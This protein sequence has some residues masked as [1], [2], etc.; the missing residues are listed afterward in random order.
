MLAS[1]LSLA[2]CNSTASS[3]TSAAISS[4]SLPSLLLHQS[5]V[6][7]KLIKFTPVLARQVYAG[8]ALNYEDLQGVYEAKTGNDPV[9]K[10]YKPLYN[11]LVAESLPSKGSGFPE[12]LLMDTSVNSSPTSS[13][14]QGGHAQILLEER[15]SAH[16]AWRIIEDPQTFMSLLPHLQPILSTKVNLKS[17]VMTPADAVAITTQSFTAWENGINHT[18]APQGFPQILDY[19]TTFVTNYDFSS[20]KEWT[21]SGAFGKGWT[22]HYNWS[23]SQ[24]SVGTPI[25]IPVSGGA[26]VFYNAELSD[27]LSSPTGSNRYLTASPYGKHLKLKSITQQA[28]MQ[29]AV[30]I[31]AKNPKAGSS[32]PS[33][34]VVGVTSSPSQVEATSL[35]G[36]TLPIL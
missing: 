28:N 2:A 17:L 36:A 16:S 6:I 22:S 4:S 9:P 29:Y 21:E 15:T 32:Q 31:P 13:T 23:A 11:H 24:S 14:A 27:R 25:V 33:I 18:K 3:T 20:L 1:G 30:F 10:G 26:L 35:Y 19:K 7:D 12:M 8:S 5:Q 34:K